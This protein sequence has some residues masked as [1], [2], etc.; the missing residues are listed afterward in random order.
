M[1]LITKKIERDLSLFPLYSQDGKGMQAKVVC[2]FFCPFSSASWYVLE[3]EKQEDED[4]LF[5]CFGGA[6][7]NFFEFGY[8]KLKELENSKIIER[9]LYGLTDATL[10][11]WLRY[12]HLSHYL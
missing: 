8:T 3:S 1:K 6:D 9:D 4:M 12:D 7:S 10:E 5:Y 11:E 2:K